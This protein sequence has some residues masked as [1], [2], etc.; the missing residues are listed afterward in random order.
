MLPKEFEA[1]WRRSHVA[2]MPADV[3]PNRRSEI[4]QICSLDVA[5]RKVKK[6]KHERTN[7]AVTVSAA[8]AGGGVF[9]D[10]LTGGLHDR[11]ISLMPP[12]LRRALRRA[13][14]VAS[15]DSW[16]E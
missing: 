2:E 11:L 4:A 9:L 12:G 1:L 3:E 14:Y 6:A 13:T 8:P 7:T 5:P 10:V 15:G 16:H